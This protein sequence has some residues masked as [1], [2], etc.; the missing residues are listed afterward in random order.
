MYVKRKSVFPPR[1]T[2]NAPFKVAHIGSIWRNSGQNL[3]RVL[4]MYL[5]ALKGNFYAL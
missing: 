4:I 1:P 2:L 5:R 3:D